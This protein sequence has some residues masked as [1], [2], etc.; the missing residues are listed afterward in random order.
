MYEDLWNGKPLV[1]IAIPDDILVSGFVF[2]DAH[3]AGKVIK[4]DTGLPDNPS[5]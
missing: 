2:D 5:L 3:L 1:N 4:Q